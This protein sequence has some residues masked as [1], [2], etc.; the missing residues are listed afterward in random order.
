MATPAPDPRVAAAEAA[1]RIAGAESRGG[2]VVG[3]TART[4]VLLLRSAG[5]TIGLIILLFFV[6]VAVLGPLLAPED[7]NSADAFSSD[8]LEAPSS[9]HLLGT[10]DNGRD[11]L[12]QLILGTQISMLIGFS[13][14]LVSAVVGSIVGICAGY[15]GG[16]VDRVLTAVDDWFLVLPYV[17]TMIVVASL[18]GDRAESWPL[19][20]VSV[21]ILVIG[22]LGWAGT[23]RIVRSEVLSVR[24]RPFVERAQ[25]LGASNWWIMRR[26]ILPN[27]VPLI[28]ANT[29]LFVALSI[30]TES[31]LSFLGLGDPTHS[32][33][34]Q[35][36]SNANQAGAQSIGAWWYFLPPG[37]CI[38]LVVLGFSLVGYAVEEIVNPRLRERR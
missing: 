25:A 1:A 9:A 38:T 5:G 34:G 22:L 23:S 10:D 19:G 29:V 7:P 32:S 6:I 28:F 4:V 31:L 26:Q 2:R 37:I 20:R 21:L 12:S 30:L 3:G 11:V 33:W 13:A 18:L 24:Q 27:V 8:I 16:W 14:A 17:P 36:L 15:F 35:M